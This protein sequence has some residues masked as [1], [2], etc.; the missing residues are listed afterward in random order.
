[1]TV[2]D[3]HMTLQYFAQRKFVTLILHAH[4]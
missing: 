1:V 3:Q 2:N 4:D